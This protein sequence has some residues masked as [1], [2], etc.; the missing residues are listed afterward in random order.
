VRCAVGG[1]LGEARSRERRGESGFAF[2]LLRRGG[3]SAG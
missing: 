2:D 1:G 3:E